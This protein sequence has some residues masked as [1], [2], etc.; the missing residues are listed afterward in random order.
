[1]EATPYLENTQ[2][3]VEIPIRYQ[4]A[5]M[6]D[7]TGSDIDVITEWVANPRDFLFIWGVSGI[8]KSHLLAAI[9]KA[10]RRSGK[11]CGYKK[12]PEIFLD[13]RQSFKNDM[14]S[15][16]IK[17]YRQPIVACFDD[18]GASNVT[19]YAVAAWYLI[20]DHR[21][22]EMTPTV[23]TSNLSLD[24]ISELMGDRIASRLASGVR[25][26]LKGLDRRL[27]PQGSQAVKRE[28]V[29]TKEPWWN[30]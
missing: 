11:K 19:D 2:A 5:E 8:G 26:E 25:F 7:F 16:V 6:S 30:K 24:K 14:E 9:T 3:W 21:Y 20:I 29:P 1:M 18:V 4:D 23:F 15:E 17:K 13:L 12:A 22:S 10:V 27:K 28:P